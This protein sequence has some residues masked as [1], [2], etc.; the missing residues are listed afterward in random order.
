MCVYVCMYVYVVCVSVL[1]ALCMWGGVSVCDVYGV[2]D[3][4][5]SVYVV[6]VWYVCRCM[7]MW[8]ACLCVCDVCLWVCVYVV[9]V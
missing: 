9:C 5:V 7:C 6:C 2:C 8:Y 4:C 1:C 3:L